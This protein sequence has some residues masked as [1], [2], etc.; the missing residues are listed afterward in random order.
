MPLY[1]YKCDTCDFLAEYVFKIEEKDKRDGVVGTPC[2]DCEDGIVFRVFSTQG[3][4]DG[5]MRKADRRMVD[6]GV[7][8]QL[9][10]IKENHPY[11]KWKG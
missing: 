4:M 6:S 10:R 3:Q 5:N 1:Q 7:G 11:M 9:N 2:P 8:D